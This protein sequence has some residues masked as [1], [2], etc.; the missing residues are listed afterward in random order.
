[1]RLSPEQVERYSRQIMIPDVGGGG[2]IRDR[3]ESLGGFVETWRESRGDDYQNVNMELV[4]KSA[5]LRDIMD[6][7]AGFGET[8]HW[9]YNAAGRDPVDDAPN[10][11]LSVSVSTD[12]DDEAL[13]WIIGGVV[14]VGVVGVA[15]SAITLVVLARRRR[16]SAAISVVDLEPASEI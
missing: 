5:D 7:G 6:F 12:R 4:V 1:M 11:R 16:R 15:V 9:E 10:A 13:P 8:E 2:Q 3:A 14:T